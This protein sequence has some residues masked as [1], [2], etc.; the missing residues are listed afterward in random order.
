MPADVSP[1]VRPNSVTPTPPGTGLR[2]EPL[3]QGGRLT[4][5]VGPSGSP[6]DVRRW[7]G[8][9]GLVDVTVT[10][11]GALGYFRGVRAGG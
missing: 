6:A 10:T 11:A 5:L 1:S 3:R 8:E 9:A 7:L 4:H 2:Y